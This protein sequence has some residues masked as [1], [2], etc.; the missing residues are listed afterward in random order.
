MSPVKI[1]VIVTIHNAEAYLRECLDS[2]LNQTLPELEI[3]CI[4]GGSTD[5]SPAILLE[6]AQRDL[7]IRIINDPNTS[8]GHKVNV[9]IEQAVGEYISVLES[10][11]KYEYDM[12][13]RLYEIAQIYRVDFVNGEYRYFFD[14]EGQRFVV[15]H[16]LYQKQPYHTLIQNAA[17]PEQLEVM[18]RFWTGIFRKGFLVEK[19][20]RLNESPGA[21]FQDMSFRFLTSVL[22]ETVYHLDVPVY[23]YRMDNPGSS[24]KDPSK[25]VVIAK[26]HA[27]L[28]EQL[29]EK[30]ITEEA[31]WQLAYYWKY[32]DFYGNLQRLEGPGRQALL[33]CY[34]QELE[35][36][37]PRLPCYSE[38][39]Y[40]HTGR[41]IL[42]HPDSF[43]AQIEEAFQAYR[44]N[45][46][47]YYALYAA[48]AKAERLVIFG[49]GKK[50]QAL[51]GLLYSVWDKVICYTDNDS[52]LWGQTCGERPICSPEEAVRHKEN[53][54]YL[55][56]NRYHA[57]EIREQLLQMQV[58]EEQIIRVP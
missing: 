16:R 43:A 22:A 40:P 4:D 50:G 29:R 11:D 35:K 14:V 7:R 42:E 5:A 46:A 57:E 9:G 51:A 27:Y 15:P 47:Q 41:E 10:D 6:Y 21:S 31:V 44:K 55:V 20:I 23:Q 58:S 30:Q 48:V 8:Y 52:R 49:S 45:N 26:E 38:A 17:H 18:D 12:L 19:Q 53:T 3:L 56:A 54:L 1:S 34:L 28:Q 39:A 33:E 36:D 37:L 13:E 32:M 24:M 2:V 25:T